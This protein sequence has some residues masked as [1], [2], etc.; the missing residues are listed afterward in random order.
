[1]SVTLQKTVQSKIDNV[2]KYVFDVNGQLVEASFIDK[3]DG[4][5]ILCL[6]S[7]SRCAMGC[8]FCQ[9]TT[10]GGRAKNLTSADLC[11]MVNA[12]LCSREP[13]PDGTLLL[14]FMGAGEPTLNRDNVIETMRSARIRYLQRYQSVRFAFASICASP[15]A[16]AMFGRDVWTNNL[17]CKLHLSLHATNDETRKDLMPATHSVRESIAAADCYQQVANQPVEIHYT[18][19]EGVNDSAADVTRLAEIARP[20][21]WP[22]KLLD[23]A[24]AGGLEK[25]D[26]YQESYRSF[27]QALESLGC[28]VEYYLPPGRDIGASCGQFLVDELG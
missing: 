3:R 15:L 1:M 17:E 26:Q 27:G 5:H 6:P 25:S 11:Q 24:P 14:S 8:K 13:L 28:Q 12:S 2:T 16:L 18:P 19:I 9:M 20:R 4:K 23:F 21:D 7:Q 10:L 22:I